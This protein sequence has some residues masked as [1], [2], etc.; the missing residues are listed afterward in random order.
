M[1]LLSFT[2]SLSKSPLPLERGR[3]SRINVAPFPAPAREEGERET[4]FGK[5]SLR[6]RHY[7]R[8]YTTRRF[9]QRDGVTAISKKIN[10]E[11][12]TR[13]RGPSA[14]AALPFCSFPTLRRSPCAAEL[15]RALLCWLFGH[16]LFGPHPPLLS[17]FCLSATMN[18]RGLKEYMTEEGEK[19][20]SP[21]RL[22][23]CVNHNERPHFM[24]FPSPLQQQEFLLRHTPKKRIMNGAIRAHPF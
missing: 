9:D 19:K 15:A 13:K 8:R 18:G 12:L 21:R 20:L 2:R 11:T 17:G 5:T 3:R 10:S 7:V 1:L 22:A 23:Q 16:Q 6:R 4:S 14:F 24:V